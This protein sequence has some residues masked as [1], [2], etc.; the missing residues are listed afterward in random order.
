MR[1]ILLGMAD[2]HSRDPAHALF[3][4]PPGCAGWR[5][6]KMM[7]SAAGVTPEYYATN[8]DRRNLCLTEWDRGLAVVAAA[9][10]RGA[11]RPGDRVVLLGLEVWKS[12]LLGPPKRPREKLVD[13]AE[14]YYLPHPSG[15]NLYYNDAME[16][17]WTGKFLANLVGRDI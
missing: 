4:D 6:W 12:F 15:R 14:W 2:P 1:P 16:R 13:V 5:L 11:V 3:P 17:W 8:F 10:L 7:D 9:E